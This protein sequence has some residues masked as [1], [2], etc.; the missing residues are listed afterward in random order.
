MI[1]GS[2]VLVST[3]S[4]TASK[5]LAARMFKVVV[6]DEASQA[7]EAAVSVPLVGPA[8]CCCYCIC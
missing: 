5:D 8:T 1:P 6:L 3:L 7:T 2:Q 4:G